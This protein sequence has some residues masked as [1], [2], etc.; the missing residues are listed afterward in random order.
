MARITDAAFRS[1]CRTYGAGMTVTELI[2]AK[3]LLQ[4]PERVEKHCQ[5]AENE[6]NFAVQ[7]FG[8]EP[9][10]M[11]KAAKLVEPYCDFID[12]NL[13]CPA[14][15]ICRVGAGSELLRNPKAIGNLVQEMR[16]AVNIPITVKTRTGINDSL[17][18]IQEVLHEVEDAGA[19]LLSI[20][21]RTRDQGYSGNANWDIIKQVKQEARIPIVGNGDITSPETAKE[22]LQYSGVDYASIG[23]AAS[24][25]PYLFKQIN[26]FLETGSYKEL[27]SSQRLAIFQKYLELSRSFDTKFLLQKIQAQHFTKGLVG[28]SVM[29]EQI[30]RARTSEELLAA[31]SASVEE[32]D[33]SRS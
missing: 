31:V 20:H 10:D 7:L 8:A 16:S 28:G 30:S 26:D 33:G 13:G 3:G 2:N 12:I 14:Y 17:I 29:R 24:G 22:K 19:S 4:H 15:K 9:K 1:L 23:R 21:G 5:R 27:S 32:H 6:D 18:T 11:A 25:N